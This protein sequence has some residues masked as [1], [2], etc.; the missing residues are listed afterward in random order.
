MRSFW[1]QRREGT[2]RGLSLLGGGQWRFRQCGQ[3]THLATGARFTFAVQVQLQFR[4]ADRR[5]PLRL[6]M[7]PAIAE[8]VDHGRGAQLPCRPQG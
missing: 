1:C 7:L 4:F 6:A 8:E 5:L 2:S 3:V